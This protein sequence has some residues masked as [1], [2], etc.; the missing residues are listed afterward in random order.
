[1]GN[2]N[3][4]NTNHQKKTISFDGGFSLNWQMNVELCPKQVSIFE[5]T[6]VLSCDEKIM[7]FDFATMKRCWYTD[8]FSAILFVLPLQDGLA[9]FGQDG[10][11]AVLDSMTGEVKW[12]RETGVSATMPLLC[13]EKI[14]IATG[15]ILSCLDVADG[16]IIWAFETPENI[17]A[18]PSCRDGRIV[19]VDSGGHVFC[20]A[21]P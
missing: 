1:M 15:N 12:S 3:C 18:G 13:F 19:V 9:I 16:H 8:R 10:N 20:L 2:S 7:G 21:P 4:K 11:S 14:F 17:V 5:R 6:C